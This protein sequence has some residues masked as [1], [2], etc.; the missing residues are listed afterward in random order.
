MKAIIDYY[1]S[2]II[3]LEKQNEFFLLHKRKKIFFFIGLVFIIFSQVYFFYKID[4]SVEYSRKDASGFSHD[5]GKEFIYFYYYL[6]LFPLTTSYSPIIYSREGAL[7]NIREHGDSL[8]MEYGHWSRLGE[9]VK[10]LLYLPH[11]YINGS[12]SN[13]SIIPFNRIIFIMSLL[14][15]YLAFWKFGFPLLG[16]CIS[17]LIGSNPFL[18]FETYGRENIFAL[19]AVTT[20]FLLSLNFVFFKN[21]KKNIYMWILPIL[22]GIII[23]TAA[24]IRAENSV[25]MISC[26]FVYFTIINFNK[27]HKFLLS[28]VLILSFISTKA[29][30]QNYF[31]YK[32]QE[33]YSLVKKAGGNT[34]DGHRYNS[35]TIW[36]P[37]FCGLGD[38]DTK[39]NYKWDDRV[40]YNYA[41]PILKDKYDLNLDYSG[42]YGLNEY[43]D[44]E[45][46]YYKKI[47]LFNEYDEVIKDKVLT[48]I[49]NDPIWYIEIIGKRIIS[50]FKDT[51]PVWLKL[52]S[53]EL[54]L[55][56]NGLWVIPFIILFLLW[57]K[58][59]ELK[60]LVFS[61]PLATTSILFYSGGDNT[62][63]SIF[64]LFFVALLLSWIVELFFIKFKN[65]PNL[66]DA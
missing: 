61:F 12:P 26:L 53:I 43:Y 42:G 66:K 59:F 49:S 21:P 39:Y 35:H 58:W 6:D 7:N 10:I 2:T 23:A 8:L 28:V 25:L 27:A 65:K 33:S 4:V 46:K 47:E 24:H 36:H 56:I 48:D 60:L 41:L 51:S 64:H 40:A 9:N 30:W 3:N 57:K 44:S 17:I 54:K 52:A 5:Y 20:L 16:F 13:P 37:L 31:D 11:A 22:S 18:L 45:K 34:Y 14:A 38:Y 55:P 19:M 63:N 15:V 32:F 62:F 50:V 1:K 29:I